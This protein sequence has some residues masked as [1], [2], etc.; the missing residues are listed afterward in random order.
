MIRI[1]WLGI[2]AAAMAAAQGKPAD[3]LAEAGRNAERRVAEWSALA[4][5]LEARMA[6]LLPCDPQARTAITE[7]SRASDQRIDALSQYLRAVIAKARDE[8]AAAKRL[9]T[10]QE[11]TL[12]DW[13][14]DF[15][16]AE[17]DRNAIGGQ[18]SSLNE[19]VRRRPAL[20]DAQHALEEIAGD[21]QR[22]VEQAADRSARMAAVTTALRELVAAYDSR[23]VSLERELSALSAEATRWTAYYAARAARA[24]TE[25][26]VTTGTP[27]ERPGQ[28]A[29]RSPR[30]KKP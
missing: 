1:V 13:E 22:H 4:G 7:V 12:A 29:P 15:S 23:Q 2:I 27:V 21:S 24:Q 30:N 19:S 10:D 8:A 17:Q 26:S 25:C 6:R 3:P 5:G 14:T 9:L 11:A 28:G 20:A 18:T 16:E